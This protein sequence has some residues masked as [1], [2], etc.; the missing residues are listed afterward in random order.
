MDPDIT[1]LHSRDLLRLAIWTWQVWSTRKGSSPD[2]QTK[3]DSEAKPDTLELIE[4]DTFEWKRLDPF[5]CCGSTEYLEES[6]VSNEIC[7]SHTDLPS[8]KDQYKVKFMQANWYLLQK[9]RTL[10]SVLGY[11]GYKR[12]IKPDSTRNKTSCNSLSVPNRLSRQSGDYVEDFNFCFSYY[13]LSTQH[14]KS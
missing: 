13:I 10:H 3:G 2:H 6:Y 9:W 12:I 7:P 14:S 1:F 8:H 11:T 4:A 5:S